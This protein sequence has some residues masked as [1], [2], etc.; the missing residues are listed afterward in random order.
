MKGIA[1]VLGLL[2]L[3][4]PARADTVLDVLARA[5]LLGTW[6]ESCSAGPS[7]QNWFVTF[8]ATTNGLIQRKSVRGGSDPVLEGTVDSAERIA[9]TVLRL[10]LRNDDPNWGEANGA[11]YDTVVEIRDGKSHAV[12]S[13]RSDGTQLIKDGKFVTSGTPTPVLQRCN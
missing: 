6:A 13:I 9:P 4:S 1:T 11:V 8:Y 3:A 2:L 5:G 10:R 7:R 12:S